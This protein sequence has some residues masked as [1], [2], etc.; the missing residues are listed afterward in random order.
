MHI[1]L[2]KFEIHMDIHL[3]TL[4]RKKIKSRTIS[5]REIIT[6]GEVGPSNKTTTLEEPKRENQEKMNM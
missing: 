4:G 1:K 6:N 3:S 2:C 5:S